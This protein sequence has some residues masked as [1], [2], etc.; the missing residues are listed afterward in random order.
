MEMPVDEN[1]I[2]RAEKPVLDH[3]VFRMEI[4]VV[5][6]PLLDMVM[7]HRLPQHRLCHHLPFTLVKKN[8]MPVK[9]IIIAKL[10]VSV[11]DP[12]CKRGRLRAR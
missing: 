2:F 7:L 9:Y 8:Q 5:I 12:L 6:C 11:D 10:C 4:A 3:P 1:M